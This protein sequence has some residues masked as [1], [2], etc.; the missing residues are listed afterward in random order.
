[1]NNL[2]EFWMVMRLSGKEV[3][4]IDSLPHKRYGSL[5]AAERDALRLTKENPNAKG[6]VILKLVA[7]FTPMIEVKD[8]A[9]V[10]IE[11]AGGAY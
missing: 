9:P 7:A 2:T 8:P 11:P 3:Q 4:Q 10:R 5:E 1:M 6:Y